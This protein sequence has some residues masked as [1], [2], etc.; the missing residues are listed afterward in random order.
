[1]ATAPRMYR[2]FSNAAE[3]EHR[4]NELEQAARVQMDKCSDDD[5]RQ[6]IADFLDDPAEAFVHASRAGGL[7][8]MAGLV[9][10]CLIRE[11]WKRQ[12]EREL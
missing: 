9:S 12:V 4:V 6:L 1:M 5:L 3:A 10:L 8:H 2:A 7:S 11:L